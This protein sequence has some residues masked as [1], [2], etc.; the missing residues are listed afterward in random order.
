MLRFFYL[1]LDTARGY[2]LAQVL[3]LPTIRRYRSLVREH[4]PRD[5]SRRVLEIGCGVGAA[6]EWFADDYTGIDINPDYIRRARREVAGNFHVMDA[7]QMSF[8]S[9]AFDDAVSTATAHHLTDEQ[10]SSMITKATS[11]A[12]NLHIIDAFLPIS[13]KQRLEKPCFRWIADDMLAPST[14]C[15]TS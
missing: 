15:A 8:G 3:G 6:R 7:A 12:S 13:P 4:V 14:S 10:L 11:V 1:L 2:R 5:P 9:D